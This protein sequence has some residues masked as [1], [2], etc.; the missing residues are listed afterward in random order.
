MK[1]FLVI[2]LSSAALFAASNSD[3]SF[4]RSGH[5]SPIV[6]AEQKGGPVD[7]S[8]PTGPADNQI[9]NEVDAGI[10]RLKASLTLTADQEKHWPGLQTALHDYGVVEFKDHADRGSRRHHRRDRDEETD[11]A[12]RS[13][14]IVQ[15]RN[16]AEDLTVRA[17]SL[18]KLADAA[19]PLYNGLDDRQKYKLIQ[20]IKSDLEGEHR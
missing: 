3:V 17:A 15:M 7:Q 8:E 10:A 18:K 20:F 1:K 11:R 12:D 9:A 5:A 6:I 14:D 2:G 16:L 4:A 13:N 19:E